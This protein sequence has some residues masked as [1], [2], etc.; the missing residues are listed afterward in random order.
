MIESLISIA[1]YLSTALTAVIL[2]LPSQYKSK[3]RLNQPDGQQRS[4]FQIL[5]LGDVGRSPRMQYHALSIAKHGGRVCIIGYNGKQLRGMSTVYGQVLIRVY[6]ES[7]THPDISS[8]PNIS[9]VPLSPHPAVLQT[10]N[11]LLFLLCAP[12]KVVFQVICLWSCLAYR[13]NPASWLLVQ[14]S[15]VLER[16]SI[17]RGIQAIV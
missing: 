13:T 7:E 5:V 2:L 1:F 16:R 6:I 10:S 12:L 3:Q 14:V 9:I 17:C 4:T 11:K 15:S 8:H